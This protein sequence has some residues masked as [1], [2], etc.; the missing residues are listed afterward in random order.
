MDNTIKVI[1]NADDFGFS[2]GV[3][4]GII[5]A[6]EQGIV[7]SATIM[8][9]MPGFEHAIS[10]A[11]QHPTLRIGVH[12]NITCGKPVQNVQRTLTN[13]DGYFNRKNSH[14]YRDEEVFQEFCAQIEKVL[15]AGIKIDHF[16]SHHH[17]HTEKQYKAVI[18]QL[19]KKYPYPIRGGFAYKNDYPHQSILCMDFYDRNVQ[20][21]K[22]KDIIHTFEPD[23]IY[24]LMCHPAYI[25]DILVDYSSYIMKRVEE[26]GILCSNEIKQEI[27]HSQIELTTYSCI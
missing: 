5:K 22:L 6:H 19:L 18:D 17:I 14:M 8:A 26:L 23:H 16:D 21:K 4:Y 27:K 15:C 7:T 24:D 12:L 25:D 2:E 13:K 1:V 3:N 11:K 9:N 10:L 20:L